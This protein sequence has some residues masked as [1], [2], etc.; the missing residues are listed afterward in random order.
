MTRFIYTFVFSI[1]SIILFSQ[2]VVK[3]SAPDNLRY[4]RIFTS[5]SKDTIITIALDQNDY[6]YVVYS[7][8]Y[9]TTWNVRATSMSIPSNSDLTFYSDTLH[10]GFEK[11]TNFGSTF[12]STTNPGY[13]A[14]AKNG[15]LIYRDEGYIRKSKDGGKIWQSSPFNIG[16]WTNAV[17]TLSSGRILIFGDPNVG[18]TTGPNNNSVI[19]SDDN[20]ETFNAINTAP[21]LSSFITKPIVAEVNGV[22]YTIRYEGFFRSL[23][24]GLNWNFVSYPRPYNISNL[25]G[26]DNKLYATSNSTIFGDT[27]S[28]MR[29]TSSVLDNYLSF[30]AS[31]DAPLEFDAAFSDAVRGKNSDLFCT[32]DNSPS[33]FTNYYKG[34]YKVTFPASLPVE[35]VKF[36]G[37]KQNGNILLSWNTQN[38]DNI[39]GYRVQKSSNGKDFT[40]IGYVDSKGNGTNNYDFADDIVVGLQYYRLDIL[41]KDL[42][43]T[44]SKVITIDNKL[45]SVKAIVYPNPTKDFVTVTIR[46]NKEN[47]I[48]ISLYDIFGR[49][50]I[51][52]IHEIKI[53]ENSFELNLQYLSTGTYNM[54]TSFLNGSLINNKV[55]VKN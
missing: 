22:L 30:V 36:E 54:Q 32:A 4:K 42:S 45:E 39:K 31:I 11:S 29:L 27:Y 5:P 9:G 43:N 55:I 51:S 12:V 8:N 28:L 35:L 46:A 38:E 18:F 49:K 15:T 40:A 33:M 20:G 7:L 16:R 34:I 10:Y 1:F 44:Y 23:D 3:L 14:T 21:P 25:F 48:E 24:Q 13:F 37:K 6:R 47:K 41:E 53:G 17:F 52:N 50:V 2:T 19:Y 26:I